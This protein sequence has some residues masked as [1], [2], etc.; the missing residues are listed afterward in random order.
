MDTITTAIIAALAT[1]SKDA[2]KDGYNALKSSLKKKIGSESELVSAV[3]QL[4]KNP[5]SK[6]RQTTLQEKVEKAKVNND[7]EILQ[8]AQNLL[9]KLEDEPSGQQIINQIQTNTA[10]GNTVSGNFIFSPKQEGTKDT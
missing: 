9:K 2:I 4:E 3:N 6:D 5:D 8:L 7:P 1:L 10:S